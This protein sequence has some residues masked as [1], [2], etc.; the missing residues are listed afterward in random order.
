[1]EKAI[2]WV[3]LY[4]TEQ[5]FSLILFH[6][7]VIYPADSAIQLSEQLGYELPATGLT[8]GA[9]QQLQLDLRL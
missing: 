5:L 7:I 6:R 1:M 2:H 9:H 8:V 4:W 3:F